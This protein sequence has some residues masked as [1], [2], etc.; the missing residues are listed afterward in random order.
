MLILHAGFEDDHLLLWGEAPLGASPSHRRRRATTNHPPNPFDAGEGKLVAAMATGCVPVLLSLK[1]RCRPVDTWLPTVAGQPIPSSSLIADAPVAKEGMDVAP[2]SVTAMA[3]PAGQAVSL[4]ASLGERDLLAPGVVVGRDLAFWGTALRFAGAMV[5]RQ[6]FLPGVAQDQHG[7]HGRWMTCLT[8]TESQKLTALASAMPGAARSVTL[9]NRRPE[10]SAKQVLGCFV[11]WM[12]DH[13]IRSSMPHTLPASPRKPLPKQGT[14][15]VNLHE[16]WMSALQSAN[17][18]IPGEQKQ[19]EELTAQVYAWQR[20]VTLTASSPYRLCFRLE[21]PMDGGD[22]WYV[23]FLLRSVADPSLLIPTENAWKVRGKYATHFKKEGFDVREYLLT[24]LGQASPLL[25]LIERSL[26]DPEPAGFDLETG[27][28]HR[29]LTYSAF[30]LE[31][32]GFGVLLPNWWSGGK[33]RPRL[34]L[35]AK[36]KSPKMR[37]GSGMGMEEIVRFDWEIALG[38]ETLSY[39]ELM[40]LAKLKS[41]LVRVRGQW[42][43]VNPEEMQE[44]LTFWKKRQEGSATV[45]D[46]LRMAIGAEQ[47][48]STLELEQVQAEGW[49]GELLDRMEGRQGLE[50]LPLPEGFHGI[51]R[52]YQERGFAWLDFLGN[53]GLGACLA[54]DMGLG[55]TVQTLAMIRRLRTQGSHTSGP[56]LLVCPTSVMGN[57]QK[58]IARFT[59]GLTVLVHHGSGR[60]GP[61]EFQEQARKHDM[62]ISS[63]ALLH[64]DQAYLQ[65]VEWAGV[66]LDEAQNI[67]NP[68]TKQS[69][70]ARSL[71]AAF[72]IAL[73]GTP[74]EN[75]VGDLWSIMEFL[76]PGFL[77]GQSQFKK[78]FFVPIQTRRD[79]EAMSRLKRI[80]GPFV[81]RRL[82]TDPSIISDLP[83]KL[84]MKVYCN[85]TK[86]QATLYA[87]VVEEA[88]RQIAA[89]GGMQRRGVVLATLSKLK[90]VCNHPAQFLGDKSSIPDR[91]GKLA[92]L[93]EMLEEIRAVEDRTLIFT[94]FAEMG[95]MLRNHLQETVG[96]EVLFLHGAVSKANR[97]RMVERFQSSHGPH[98]FILSLKAGGTGLN[99]TR[100]NHVFHFDRWWNPAVEN[101]ATDRAFRIGQTKNVQVHKFLCMGTLEEKIDEMIE[102]K[103][104]MAD[105]VVGAGENWLTEMSDDQL[106]ELFALRREAFEES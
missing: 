71:P 39:K 44:A 54:D 70:A 95:T 35:R 85:L 41:S 79:G 80:T 17:D 69:K 64:R 49:V 60:H 88:H 21:E 33:N 48:S 86:E 23:R 15:R 61:E 84:E 3:M 99:L 1:E 13:L 104:R 40:D 29:F 30:L 32:N 89:A 105:E 51:L 20:P 73:T 63:Y 42:V 68:E 72:R 26:R 8:E 4:L 6:R 12:A 67:K 38:G 53:F 92:R 59:S 96:E 101:Q 103:R 76:N 47:V 102:A 37:G 43:E 10:T 19:W 93:S 18:A 45:R 14:E 77:G 106:R 24:A 82:K 90:Q 87:A 52:P 74:V 36:V 62:V 57:W 28:A 91:S 100:A 46:I 7:A 50:T 98:V 56:V 16:G 5:A 9:I 11:D 55:K 65:D 22:D 31:E 58:E 66:I 97:D 81:L 78:A 2:W 75:N 83:D 34:R 27:E 25:P 94:Q